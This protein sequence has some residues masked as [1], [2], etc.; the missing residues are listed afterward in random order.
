MRVAACALTLCLAVGPALAPAPK[1]APAGR[2]AAAAAPKKADDLGAGSST[3][4][5]RLL[6]F[7]LAWTS[8]DNGLITGTPGG[9]KAAMVRVICVRDCGH[10]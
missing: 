1:A 2:P 9:R 5:R 8:D 6:Q 4:K 10:A 7:D 3:N